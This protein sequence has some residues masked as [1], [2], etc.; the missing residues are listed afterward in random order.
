MTYKYET[1]LKRG[2]FSCLSIILDVFLLPL[3]VK[4]AWNNIVV[5]V[6]KVSTITYIQ[7]FGLKFGYSA[8]TSNWF[9][10]WSIISRSENR[11]DEYGNMM[12]TRI[13]QLADQIKTLFTVNNVPVSTSNWGYGY[14]EN[15]SG[16]NMT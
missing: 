11:F 2:I 7:A 4:E 12:S 13:L 16:V 10:E 6:V 15:V 9:S 14:N 5:D 1:T 8:F 3:I